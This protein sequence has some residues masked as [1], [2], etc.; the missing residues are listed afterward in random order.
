MEGD[1]L[2]VRQLKYFAEVCNSGSFAQAAEACHLS[3]QGISTA[4]MRLEQEFGVGI[5]TMALA[6]RLSRSHVCAVPFIEPELQWNIYLI[7]NKNISL[8]PEAKAFDGR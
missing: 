7:K 2:D 8:S 4:I 3:P 6:K 1:L 5:S